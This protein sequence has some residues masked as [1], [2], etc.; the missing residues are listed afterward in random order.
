MLRLA[1]RV[2][3]FRIG[4]ISTVSSSYA[5]KPTKPAQFQNGPKET[6]FQVFTQMTLFLSIRSPE[7][8]DQFPKSVSQ[9]LVLNFLD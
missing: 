5:L 4:N 9:F 2:S 3:P 8:H 7:F 1:N 6:S